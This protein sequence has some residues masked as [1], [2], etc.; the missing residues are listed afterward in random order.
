MLP[1]GAL[2]LDQTSRTPYPA[3]ARAG[4][5]SILVA[6]PAPRRALPAVGGFAI[7]S[8]RLGERRS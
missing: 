7:A 1:D 6:Q 4:F 3:A 2:H 5:G 8:A